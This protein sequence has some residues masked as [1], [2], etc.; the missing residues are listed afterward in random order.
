MN[1]G[2]ERSDEV[3]NLIV[4]QIA[5]LQQEACEIWAGHEQE[6][7]IAIVRALDTVAVVKLMDAHHEVPTRR[8]EA[9]HYAIRG[10]ATALRP[11]LEKIRDI[12]GGL[13]WGPIN[14]D[15]LDFTYSYIAG[16]GKL[17]HLHRMASLKRFGL[18]KTNVSDETV[19]IE[20]SLG[21]EEFVQRY[22]MEALKSD[23]TPTPVHGKK[24]TRD[25]LRR[26][27]AYVGS[28]DGWFIRY[29]NDMEIVH[30]YRH[31]A[32]EYGVDFLEGEALPDEVVIGDRSFAKWREACDQALGRILC[33][34]DFCHHLRQKCPGI[35][36]GNVMT[37]F[38][39]K[40]DIEDVWRE[41]GLPADQVA[42][43]MRALTLSAVDMEAWERDF[44]VPCPIYIELGRDFL[45]LPCFGVLTNPYFALFRHLRVVH[46]PLWDNAVDER[47]KL[48]RR[49]L[50]SIFKGPRYV[51]DH[52]YL[53]KRPNK[54][55]LTDID[56]II[57]DTKSGSLAFIQFK[58]QDVFGHS[59]NERDSRRK[60]L[61]EQGNEWVERITSW[62][63]GRSAAEV[64]RKLSVK[65]VRSPNPPS[66][67]VVARYMARFSGEK[68]RD[69]RATWM[70]W[71]EMAHL[72]PCLDE[73]N[74]LESVS[75]VVAD[76]RRQFSVAEPL[77]Q[78]FEFPDLTVE[79]K[80]HMS[81]EESI[82]QSPHIDTSV[83]APPSK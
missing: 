32:A 36:L 31:N 57:V 63:D 80:T 23:Q 12:P 67:Y 7:V 49:D 79:L 61:R 62:I 14:P 35:A 54:S 21:L 19:T 53:L 20:T 38:A 73:S 11:F 68:E 4:G 15:L 17:V 3:E 47:E 46:R 51:P 40:N 42:P 6:A 29:D 74:P 52:G 58:W 69:S 5:K 72:F 18:A 43:T 28:V 78:K 59:L 50:A 44:E 41:A 70:S 33:H 10:A 77:T 25:I 48:F 55:P 9:R 82:Q 22:A 45:L 37:I 83:S 16:C 81:L 13:P 26:M 2:S 1:D 75:Q 65:G 66:L 56:A 64:A 27:R 30:T 60:N 24:R 8:D 76:Y 71:F 39:R 34:I